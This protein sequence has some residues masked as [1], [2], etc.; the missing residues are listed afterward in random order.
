[1]LGVVWTPGKDM[2]ARTHREAWIE[3]TKEDN[4]AGDIW[5][6]VKLWAYNVHS[7]SQQHWENDLR[8]P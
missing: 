5:E 8:K 1:M 4:G 6:C 2:S 3:F 7:V